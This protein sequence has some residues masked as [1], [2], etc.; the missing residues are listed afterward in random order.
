MKKPAQPRLAAAKQKA[1]TA[2]DR[3]NKIYGKSMGIGTVAGMI[4]GSIAGHLMGM[5]DTA[6]AVGAGTMLGMAA[7]QAVGNKLSNHHLL[8]NGV[9]QKKQFNKGEK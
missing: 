6:P 1:A 5:P 4:G 7:G 8:N 2:K 3:S 9:M